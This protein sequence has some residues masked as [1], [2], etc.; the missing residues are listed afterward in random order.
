VPLPE[1]EAFI[2]AQ[3]ADQPIVAYCR[4]PFCAYAGEAVRR[5]LE[6]GYEAARIEI[7]VPQWRQAGR[8]VVVA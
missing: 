4:G 8:R 7:G 6:R 1:L 2:D 5:L 3:A